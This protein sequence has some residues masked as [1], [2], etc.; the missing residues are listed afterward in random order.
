MVSAVAATA[1]RSSSIITYSKPRSISALS[2]CYGAISAVDVTVLGLVGGAPGGETP[3]VADSSAAG[4][5]RFFHNSV[6]PSKQNRLG[7]PPRTMCNVRP[8][9][10]L[11]PRLPAGDLRIR[12]VR[13]L[14][15]AGADIYG[16]VPHFGTPLCIVCLTPSPPLKRLVR[17]FLAH[18]MRATARHWWLPWP[19]ACHV[20]GFLV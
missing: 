20:A 7:K 5:G 4:A 8:F 12:V 16:A 14:L 17:K 10:Q 2:R 3:R 6:P 15:S 9:N 19:L 13:A 1:S 11:V 18:R